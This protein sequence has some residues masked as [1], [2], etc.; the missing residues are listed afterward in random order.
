[1]SDNVEEIEPGGE[2]TQYE[3]IKTVTKPHAKEGGQLGG[4]LAIR[5]HNSY[6]CSALL[7]APSTEVDASSSALEEAKAVRGERT[8]E[9]IRYGQAISEQGMGGQTTTNTGTA[10]YE[11]GYGGTKEQVGKTT[12]EGGEKQGREAQ[13]YG[14]EKDMDRTI[15]A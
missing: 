5:E 1:M 4:I 14:G 11:G 9:N 2:S 3:S 7:A 13:G 15:G 12:E 10:N 8:A 6:N